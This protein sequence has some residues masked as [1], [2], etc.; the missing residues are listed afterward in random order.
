MKKVLLP[1]KIHEDGLK[2]LN[3]QVE[4]IIAPDPSRDAVARYIRDVDGVIL[5]TTS[6]IT[7][8]MIISAPKLKVISRTGV[9]VDNIDVPTA[10]ERGVAIC[11]LPEFNN[12]SVAEH[13]VFER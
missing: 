3:G 7:R 6:R 11:N 2:V 5:R 4:V 1:Q 12:V 9:G 10:T 8:D 13:T